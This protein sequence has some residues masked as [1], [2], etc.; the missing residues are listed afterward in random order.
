[1]M[2]SYDYVYY[3]VYY[4]DLAYNVSVPLYQSMV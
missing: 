1:M 2:N 3:T 4:W